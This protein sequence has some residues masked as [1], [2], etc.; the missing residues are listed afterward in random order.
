MYGGWIIPCSSKPLKF[1][2]MKTFAKIVHSMTYTMVTTITMVV[3][4]LVSWMFAVSH[5]VLAY[6]ISIVSF[7]VFFFLSLLPIVVEEKR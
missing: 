5:L 2:V 4:L 6:E 7:V 1:D 3:S